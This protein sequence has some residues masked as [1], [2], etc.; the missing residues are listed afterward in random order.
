MLAR[1]ETAEMSKTVKKN[2]S[3]ENIFITKNPKPFIKDD[4]RATGIVN[5]NYYSISYVSLLVC[6]P[7]YLP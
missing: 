1:I 2:I 6:I 3:Y 5:P 7:Y 4:S